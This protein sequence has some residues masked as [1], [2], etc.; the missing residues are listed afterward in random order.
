M[1]KTLKVLIV[2]IPPIISALLAWWLANLPSKDRTIEIEVYE[3]NNIDYLQIP[4]SLKKEIKITYKKNEVK[5]LSSTRFLV[6][7]RSGKSPD[8]IELH[9]EFEDE[10][11]MPLLISKTIKSPKNFPTAGMTQLEQN[12]NN[13][14]NFSCK[15]NYFNHNDDPKYRFLVEFIFLG[16]KL[17]KIKPK[18]LGKNTTIVPFNRNKDQWLSVFLATFISTFFIIIYLSFFVWASNKSKESKKKFIEW[19]TGTIDTIISKK[20]KLN[21]THKNEIKEEF[22]QKYNERGITKFEKVYRNIMKTFNSDQN[23]S[24]D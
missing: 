20:I 8:N 18:I 9:F 1:K 4:E 13:P 22:V 17:P 10:V 19:L 3:D 16:S 7:N 11:N 5:N 24:N 23:N 12:A 15:L 21:Q 14:N 2:L 6:F